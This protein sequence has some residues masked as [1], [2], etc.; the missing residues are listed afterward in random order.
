MIGWIG[1]NQGQTGACLTGFAPSRKMP[2]APS[3]RLVAQ[4]QTM[5]PLVN[6]FER[7]QAEVRCLEQE[8]AKLEAERDT[9]LV[10][11]DRIRD[12]EQI[13]AI[14]QAENA[15]LRELAVELVT[16]I[17]RLLSAVE[18]YLKANPGEDMGYMLERDV[19]DAETVLRKAKALME[20]K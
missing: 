17:G 4:G 14:A 19:C 15:K 20:P 10:E 12:A 6:L 8:N 16:V 7:L 9:L 5:T 2:H 1:I 11:R 18:N 3:A 13:A